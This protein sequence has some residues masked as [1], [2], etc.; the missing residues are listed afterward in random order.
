M[1]LT[2]IEI[3]SRVNELLGKGPI[4]T[5][6]GSGKFAESIENM[7]DLLLPAILSV[8][9]WRFATA[10]KPLSRLVATPIVSNYSYA[11]QLPADFLS[12]R[13]LF[14]HTLDFQIY[15]N[16]LLYANRIELTAEYR[17]KPDESRLPESFV[18]FFIYRLA[19]M[20]AISASI[21]DETSAKINRSEEIFYKN[22]LF[23]DS[24]SHPSL[25]I[26]SNPFLECRT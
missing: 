7:Y 21:D 15:E 10:I 23:A 12:L 5:I 6:A 8:D 3:I 1:P 22:A 19:G 26:Q 17:F 25:A 20:M 14:P 11:F 13:R 9:N 4:T 16:K 24:S 18:L 2:K